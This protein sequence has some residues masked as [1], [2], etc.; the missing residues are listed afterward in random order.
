VLQVAAQAF[1]CRVEEI[2]EQSTARTVDGWTSLAHVEFLMALEQEFG[3]TMQP[4]DILRIDSIGDALE[5]LGRQADLSADG[6][7]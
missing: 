6:A 2:S 4:E 5:L 7:T 3:F 1:K